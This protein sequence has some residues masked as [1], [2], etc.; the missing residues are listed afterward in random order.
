M[1]P[2]GNR[3]TRAAAAFA[4]LAALAAMLAA[5]CYST[6][7]MESELGEADP[8]HFWTRY[9]FPP[10]KKGEIERVVISEFSVEIVTSK[11]ISAGPGAT[12]VDPT[13]IVPQ[14]RLLKTVLGIGRR[15]ADFGDDLVKELP[16][17][18]YDLTVKFL[19]ERGAKVVPRA[20]VSASRNYQDYERLPED[21]ASFF[22]RFNPVGGDTGRVRDFKVVPAEG[23]MVIDGAKDVDIESV[24]AALL[25]E[26]KADVVVRARIRI[27]VHQGRASV[28]TGS[29]ITVTGKHVLG[30]LESR[31]SLMSDEG[32]VKDGGYLP[33]QGYLYEVD[34]LLYKEE[35]KKLFP[36]YLDL[37]YRSGRKE[38]AH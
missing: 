21:E 30:S 27:G 22:R 15:K 32:I 11:V 28:E 16:T 9:D 13:E 7:T 35:M 5:G 24:D 17:L 8:D 2:R 3:A 31:R 12:A 34:P 26:L 18:L 1:P 20:Q 23:L 10:F 33:I 25:H 4:A 36:K 19:E 37:A 29:V 6:P 14:T 38:E